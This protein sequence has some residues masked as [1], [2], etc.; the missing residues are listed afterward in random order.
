MGVDDVVDAFA[1][2][3]ACG[4]WGVLAVGLFCTPD[5]TYNLNGYYGLIY[6][7]PMLIVLCLIGLFAQIAWVSITSG[8]LFGAMKAAKILRI[9]PEVEEEGMD[10]SE[11]GGSAYEGAKPEAKT[12]A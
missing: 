10:T 7:S 12:P 2:H 6:G 4:F 3:G 5:Y 9:P 8:I 1:V 11:H